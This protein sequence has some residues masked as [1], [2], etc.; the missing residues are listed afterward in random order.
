MVI[1]KSDGDIGICVDMKRANQVI[2]RERSPINTI[3]E[4]LIDLNGSTVFSRVD[5]KWG[6]NQILLAEE[7]KHVTTF[8]TTMVTIGIPD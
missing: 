7:S 5:L 4:V 2:V 8:V 1:P 3:E 6:F